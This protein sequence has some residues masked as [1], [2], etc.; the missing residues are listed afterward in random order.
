MT[1][2]LKFNVYSPC[3]IT[4]VIYLGYIVVIIIIF[5]TAFIWYL[6]ANYTFEYLYTYTTLC[7]IWMCLSFICF[8]MHSPPITVFLSSTSVYQV[9]VS[10]KYHRRANRING[11]SS[12]ALLKWKF[13]SIIPNAIPN[14]VDF[15]L[16]THTIRNI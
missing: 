1:S 8:R 3:Y 14:I 5:V 15:F 2:V 10:N 16:K 4:T 9:R 7:I 13:Q 11:L 12:K 6:I